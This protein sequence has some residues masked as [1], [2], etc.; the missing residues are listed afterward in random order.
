MARFGLTRRIEKLEIESLAGKVIHRP[1]TAEEFLELMAETNPV[2][3][4][5]GEKHTIGSFLSMVNQKGLPL[6]RQEDG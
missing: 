2:F 1:Q 3:V 5:G 4:I 6:V